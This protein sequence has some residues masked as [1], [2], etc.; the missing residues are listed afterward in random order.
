MKPLAEMVD[1]ALEEL[2]P[3]DS[4]VPQGVH[5]AMRYA[6]FSGGKRLRPVFLLS[7]AGLFGRA[8]E[9]FL[10]AACAVELVHTASLILDDL[11]CM[12]DA[13]ERRGQASTHRRFD[14]STA[15]LAAM[16]MLSEAHNRVCVNAVRLG[17]PG[18]AP[19]AV[20]LLNEAAGTSGLVRGQYLDLLHTDGQAPTETLLDIHRHKAGSLFEASLALPA[21][22]LGEDPKIIAALRTFAADVGLAFQITDDLIDAGHAGEDEGKASFAVM[23]GARGR[24]ETLIDE[25]VG[26]LGHFGGAADHLRQLAEYVRNRKV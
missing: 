22:L 20:A 10:E 14:E 13:G 16:A 2:L 3:P 26:A 19:A 23:G 1:R 5:A 18:N 12:D 7:T 25:A 17:L 8:P 21:V 9:D 24:V 11:P 15:L 6:L 4:A